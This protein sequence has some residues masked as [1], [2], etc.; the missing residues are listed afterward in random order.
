MEKL[1]NCPS[2]GGTLDDNGRCPFCGSKVYDLT[3]MVINLN[4]RDRIKLRL[5]DGKNSTIMECYP[6]EMSI[7]IDSGM[8]DTTRDY[9]GRIQFIS[10]PPT[11]TISLTLISV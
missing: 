3:D 10:M 8:A 5:T 11:T 2:C 1:N 4:S 6:A 7:S 9:D